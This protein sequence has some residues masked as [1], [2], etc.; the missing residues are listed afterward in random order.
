MERKRVEPRELS[1]VLSSC[2]PLKGTSRNG[3]ERREG[4]EKREIRI[5]G[6]PDDGPSIFSAN[7][8]PIQLLPSWDDTEERYKKVWAQG[9]QR[10]AANE[11]KRAKL[12][13]FSLQPLYR[14]KS[15]E[16]RPRER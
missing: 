12:D 7:T 14:A 11:E 6:R 13:L 8:L 1:G 10:N 2:I 5:P 9:L 16:R 4:R 15:I 3:T